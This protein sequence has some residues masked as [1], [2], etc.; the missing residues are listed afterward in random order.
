VRAHAPVALLH[1]HAT[2]EVMVLVMLSA[3]S[4]CLESNEEVAGVVIYNPID[5]LLNCLKKK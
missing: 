3:P 5:S 1:S 4:A 2:D